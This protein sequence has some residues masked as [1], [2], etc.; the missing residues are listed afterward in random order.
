MSKSIQI[1]K[2]LYKSSGYDSMKRF[3]RKLT[4]KTLFTFCKKYVK[5]ILKSPTSEKL[6]KKSKEIFS[7]YKMHF[8]VEAKKVARS[9]KKRS[10]SHREEPCVK[11]TTRKLK[12]KS[13]GVHM[14]KFSNQKRC[15]LSYL[16]DEYNKCSR[17]NSVRVKSESGMKYCMEYD[18]EMRMVQRGIGLAKR[19][20][21]ESLYSRKSRRKSSNNSRKI[22]RSGVKK[23]NTCKKRPCR[24][25]VQTCKNLGMD[26]KKC[27]RYMSKNGKYKHPDRVSRKRK[28]LQNKRFQQLN[29]CLKEKKCL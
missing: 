23:N 8:M 16:G 22:S 28:S 7:A 2:K 29:S 10:K 25:I 18:N 15:H 13:G 9:T 21:I 12:R 3:L 26:S 27:F 11:K 19:R 17:P 4:S 14:R 5:S 6:N 1:L 24:Q 20:L